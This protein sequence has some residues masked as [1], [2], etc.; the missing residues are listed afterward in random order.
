MVGTEE[1]G[2][3]GLYRVILVIDRRGRTCE[4]E[5]LVH[6]CPIGI[7]DI[8]AYQLKVRLSDQVPYVLLGTTIEIVDANHVIAFVDE[9]FA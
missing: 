1:T 2:L 7:D 3:S 8:M 5:Y 6:F 9:A 4:I